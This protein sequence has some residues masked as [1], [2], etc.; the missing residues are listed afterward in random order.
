MNNPTA[1]SIIIPV[2]NAA[3]YI[4]ECARSLF[5]QTL[6]DVEY[7]FMD[8]AST[9]DSVN[10]LKAISEE[11]PDRK[12][13]IKTHTENQGQAKLREI[14]KHIVNGT[15]IFHCDSDDWI[16]PNL[17]EA[18]YNLAVERN[19]DI[20]TCDLLYEYED[21]S[22]RRWPQHAITGRDLCSGILRAHYTGSL[23]N[24]LIRKT[25]LS[26][27]ILKP[28]YNM[29]EDWVCSVQYAHFCKSVGYVSEP[30]YHYRVHQG[31]SSFTTTSS[32]NAE[33][34]RFF[35]GNL[36]TVI[37]F[38]QREGIEGNMRDDIA[39]RYLTLRFA[40]LPYFNY[41]ENRALWKETS[42]RYDMDILK[43]R[44]IPFK[45]KLIFLFASCGIYRWVALIKNRGK[46]L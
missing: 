37:Q 14:A 17:L 30:V 46:N 35:N 5:G 39:F 13:I 22:K 8:D 12:V 33:R 27:D 40:L 44:S 11:Y 21:G 43:S 9:D 15:Y 34:Y 23:C 2:Y 31:S 28:R 1:V 29:G 26:S 25:L 42:H 32:Q 41:K 36:D 20:V 38:F 6:S 16:D 18:M 45:E 4:E 19:L 10:I 24:K 3:D 7:L